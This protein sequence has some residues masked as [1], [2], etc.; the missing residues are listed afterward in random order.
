MMKFGLALVLPLLVHSG[1]CSNTNAPALL[2]RVID[3]IGGL[4][5][6]SDIK[7]LTLQSSLFRSRALFQSYNLAVS[8]QVTGTDAT[9]T[10][11]YEFGATGLKQRIDRDLTYDDYWRHAHPTLKNDYTLVIQAG[12]NA[13]ACFNKGGAAD[14]P[15]VPWGYADSYLTDYLVHAAEQSALVDVLRQFQAAKSELKYSV[16][17]NKASRVDYPTLSHPKLN[18]QLLVTN[19]TW[20]PRAV[21][22]TENHRVYG[23]STNDIVFSDYTQISFGQSRTIRYPKLIQTVYNEFHIIEDIKVETVTVN[24]QFPAGHFNAV[25]QAAPAGA[26]GDP[27]NP[28]YPHTDDEYPRAEVHEFYESGLWYGPFGK[29][30]NASAVIVKPVFPDGSVPQ[31]KNLCVGGPGY[32]QLLIEFDDGLVITDAPAHRSKHIIQWVKENMNGKKITHVVP[33][34]HHRDHAG[35]VADYL[36]AGAKLVVPEIAKDHYKTLNNGKFDVIT[37][38]QGKPFVK[39][40]KNVQFMSFWRDENPHA[41]DWVYSVA[42]PACSGFNKSEVVV[43]NADV[44]NPN[45]APIPNWDTA[46]AMPFFVDIVRQGIPVEATLVGTHGKTPY[47]L[48]TQDSIAHLAEVAG[49]AYPSLSGTEKWCGK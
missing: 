7:G 35:G 22:S 12:A 20:L 14:H 38:T 31:I 29:A 4:E 41:R 26:A 3:A 28:H 16:T 45:F 5:S 11:S 2:S 8:D 10:I 17:Q 42:G 9:Q 18:L 13:T 49:F 39:K 34:H 15:A 6:L 43:F 25:P 21:R 40:D 36:A 46:E 32:T 44:I 47:G 30:L 23:P 33:S 48:G 19:G 27:Y 24:P 37:Y 1:R